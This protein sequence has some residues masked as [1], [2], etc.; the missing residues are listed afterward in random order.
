MV[1][2]TSKQMGQFATNVIFRPIVKDRV[3]IEDCILGVK[4]KVSA[5]SMRKL[6]S[7][8][9]APRIASASS[10]APIQCYTKSLNRAAPKSTCHK[11]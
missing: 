3:S 2:E 6:R 5:G 10:S 7:D 11:F 8:W 4:C 1:N 9:L